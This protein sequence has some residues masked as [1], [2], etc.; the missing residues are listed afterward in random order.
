MNLSKLGSFLLFIS[1]MDLF[2]TSKAIEVTSKRL[3][4]NK[5]D[6]KKLFADKFSDS[7]F[8]IIDKIG[9]EDG[10]ISFREWREYFSQIDLT[11]CLKPK[12]SIYSSHTSNQRY[13]PTSQ[14][15]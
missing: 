15:N 9:N 5:T 13:K 7:L 1:L 4:S 3:N 2:V 12:D 11:K 6:L 14:N 8:D 10:Y